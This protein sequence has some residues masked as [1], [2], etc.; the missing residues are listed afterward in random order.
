MLHYIPPCPFGIK[1]V[2]ITKIRCVEIRWWWEPNR[3][4]HVILRC[5]RSFLQL[6]FWLRTG[7]RLVVRWF[8][9]C[10]I[11][12]Q[13]LWHCFFQGSGTLAGVSCSYSTPE[14]CSRW[15]P[16]KDAVKDKGETVL[17]QVHYRKYAQGYQQWLLLVMTELLGSE[18]CYGSTRWELRS[19]DSDPRW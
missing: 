15:I 19:V 8:F 6:G 13:R 16:D 5:G 17:V 18:Y 14:S 9:S 10:G 4:E 1:E 7:F 2:P 3:K 11:M 12:F